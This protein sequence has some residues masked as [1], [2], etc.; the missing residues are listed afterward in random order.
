MA[1]KLELHAVVPQKEKPR[2][3]AWRLDW[4]AGIPL[5]IAGAALL[6][7]KEP[8]PPA[9]PALASVPNRMEFGR[10]SVPS[11]RYRTVL[12]RNQGSSDL[13]V[14]FVGIA[15]EEQGD[16]RVA[17]TTC[18]GA[19][20]PPGQTCRIRAVFRPSAL[21]RKTAKL[22]IADNAADSPQSVTLIGTGVEGEEATP[23][24]SAWKDVELHNT[25][26]AAV[27]VR[28]LYLPHDN[29]NF[30]LD[31]RNCLH[32][33]IS[34]GA[35][36]AVGVQYIPSASPSNASC[37]PELVLQPDMGHAAG[38]KKGEL[39]VK[40]CQDV[41]ASTSFTTQQNPC[42]YTGITFAGVCVHGKP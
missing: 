1:W 33:T 25:G 23:Q 31:P 10:L 41:D 11:S 29:D 39:L 4:R 2:P 8:P 28:E 5:L 32:T 15:T 13:N 38:E 26:Q 19:P 42:Q 34:G 37:T 30:K 16:F 27:I 18:E 24:A 40:V 3:K 9:Q 36:C 7:G 6:P 17:G 20:L 35:S 22:L 14:H 12:V 21:S